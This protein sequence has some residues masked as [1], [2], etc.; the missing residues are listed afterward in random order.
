MSALDHVGLSVRDYERSRE[1]YKAALGAI[2]I[3][4]LMDF[5]HD[6]KHQA[7]FGVDK[8][9]F[10]V[11]SG[12]K[13]LGE[14]H[15]AFTASSRAEV[16]AFYA[17]ALSMGGTDNGK[18]GLRPNYHPGYYGAFVNDPDGHNIEAVYHG[19]D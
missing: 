1:F 19:T 6:G 7:G 3:K 11:S 13:S 4:C 12:A 8:P 17:I 14:V 9:F 16:E 2:G 15:I 5:E 18:P 10:W